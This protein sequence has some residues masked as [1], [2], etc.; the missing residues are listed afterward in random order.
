MEDNVILSKKQI[1]QLKK[2]TL[3]VYHNLGKRVYSNG[4]IEQLFNGTGIPRE[5]I[6][7]E[8]SKIASN[9]Q[10]IKRTEKISGLESSL[11]KE[12]LKKFGGGMLKVGKGIVY[13]I[14]ISLALPTTIRKYADYTHD[15]FEGGFLPSWGFVIESLAIYLPLVLDNPKL[16]LPVALTQIGTNLASGIYEYVRS[17]K[18]RSNLA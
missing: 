9:T 1:K 15:K 8:L 13:T 14:G 17:V 11:V 6:E 2:R 3:Y 10:N 16:I 12:D 4:D 18:K 7:E 5:I